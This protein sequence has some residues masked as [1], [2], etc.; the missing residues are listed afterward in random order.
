MIATRL[1]GYELVE[2]GA[3]KVLIRSEWKESLLRDLLDDFADVGPKRRQVYGSG[4]AEHFSYLPEGGAGRVFVRRCVRGGFLRWLGNLH[5]GNARPL[6]EI[7]AVQASERAGIPVPEIVAAK[8]TRAFGPFYRLVIVMREIP[9]AANLLHAAPALSATEKRRTID[10]LADILRR[11][12]QAGIYH[13]DL[14]VHNIVLDDEGEVHVIDFDK[15]HLVESMDRGRETKMLSRLNRS[16]EKTLG[17][18]NCVTRADK[19][20]LVRRCRG[21]QEALR[22][23]C[24]RCSSGLWVHRLWWSV[25]GQA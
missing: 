3:T 20:R 9:G 18:M 5:L 10:R 7:R 13:T 4:R 2:E 16:V 19:L 8:A 22:E 1:S 24:D 25:T 11:M 6:R 17:S 23:L 12:H 14:T 15:A 21:P